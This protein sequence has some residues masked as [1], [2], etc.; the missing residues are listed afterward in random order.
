[1]A[2]DFRKIERLIEDFFRR[3]GRPA[4][5]AGGDLFIGASSP[6]V[7]R[8][9]EGHDTRPI[10]LIDEKSTPEIISLTSLAQDLAE[11]LA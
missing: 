1:M 9:G 10:M 4:C 3:H 6:Y 7:E 11:S 5:R 2:G 8:R